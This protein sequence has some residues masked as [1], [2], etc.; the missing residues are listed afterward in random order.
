MF[1]YVIFEIIL[2]LPLD[3]RNLSSPKLARIPARQI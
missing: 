3:E 2:L 1:G